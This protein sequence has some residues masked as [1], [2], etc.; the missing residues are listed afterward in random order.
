MK[1]RGSIFFCFLVLLG[2]WSC[3]VKHKG[4]I[5][6]SDVAGLGESAESDDK[7]SDS[8]S[9]TDRPSGDDSDSNTDL[10]SD[11]TDMSSL[12]QTLQEL[13][14]SLDGK[15]FSPESS[16]IGYDV[17]SPLWSDGAA[18]TRYI[19]LPPGKSLTF[20]ESRNLLV[21]PSGTMLVKHF[22]AKTDGSG[23]VETR[24]MLLREDRSW[25]FA[26]YQW[27]AD[28]STK[29]TPSS[30][31]IAANADWP[32]GYRIPSENDCAACHSASSNGVLGF[33]PAQLITSLP[34]L[35]A[36][37]VMSAE[38]VQKISGIA[39]Q[40][41]PTDSSISIKDRAL[42]YLDANCSSCHRPD[43]YMQFFHLDSQH[44]DLNKLVDEGYIVPGKPE[45]S[46]IWK[47]FT[48]SGYRMPLFSVVE[49]PLGRDVLKEWINNWPGDPLPP[50]AT[51]A[52][53]PSGINNDSILNVSVAG[54]NV[55]QYKYKIRGTGDAACSLSTGYSEA[56]VV[57]A[58]IT[59]S[60]ASLADGTYEICVIGADAAGNWQA[61]SSATTATWTKDT[62]AP[63]A[64]ISGE[65]TDPSP[66]TQL[67]VVVSGVDVTKY[68]YKLGIQAAEP[69]SN[70]APYSDEI[71]VGTAI[72][73][74]I[75]TF[76]NGIIE[77]CVIGRDSAGNWQTEA[78]ATSAKWTKQ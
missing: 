2:Q 46:L 59:D 69:C 10:P 48:A 9:K 24:V 33:K 23:A 45:E 35:A 1:I 38:L 57:A 12:P 43:G 36:A 3:F 32:S 18:K 56:K 53:Q 5:A 74:D 60:I 28:G 25:A 13:S 50:T 31:K 8:D 49:D 62:L 37:N 22:A 20:D 29:R 42:A 72:T 16:F 78:S 71:D 58:L 30:V 47:R 66:A 76:E 51:L 14:L 73:N 55:V 26:T 15:T 27:A 63:T 61:E 68:K 17:E 64:L 77:L 67:N 44:I 52:G 65:P 34:K 19:R 54:T 11:S 75:S 4:K 41:K 7:K 40:A 6:G 70:S 21:F 39:P